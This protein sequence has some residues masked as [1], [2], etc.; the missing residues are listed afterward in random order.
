MEAA[1]LDWQDTAPDI[2]DETAAPID[3]AEAQ[4]DRGEGMELDAFR[5][6]I[7]TRFAGA[8]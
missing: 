7:S 4:A 2:D 1:I 6:Q 3:Q 8:Q 5:A